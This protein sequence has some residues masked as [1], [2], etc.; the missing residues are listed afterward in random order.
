MKKSVMMTDNEPVN[1]ETNP[2]MT[3]EEALK[4]PM[5]HDVVYVMKKLRRDKITRLQYIEYVTKGDERFRW[6]VEDEVN[7]LPYGLI[8]DGEVDLYIPSYLK[9]RI[10]RLVDFWPDGRPDDDEE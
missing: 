3:M 2:E 10:P 4:D 8:S 5:A 9:K 7:H 6:T 1:P